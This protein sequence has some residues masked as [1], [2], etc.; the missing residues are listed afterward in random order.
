MRRAR[1]NQRAAERLEEFAVLHVSGSVLGD[2]AGAAGDDVLMALAA[3]LGVVDRP[4]AILDRFEFLEDESIVVERAERD[5][6]FF[7]DGIVVRPLFIEAICLVVETRRSFVGCRI[8]R[9]D[10]TRRCPGIEYPMVLPPR[11]RHGG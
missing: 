3:A 5:D 11:A 7:V 2:L 6:A 9:A 8:F 4:Q 10:S 1:V